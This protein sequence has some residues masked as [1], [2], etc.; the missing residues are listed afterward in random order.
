[1]TMNFLNVEGSTKAHGKHASR[2]VSTDPE[3]L[4]DENTFF[5]SLESEAGHS[6]YEE[7]L[8]RRNSNEVVGVASG[9]ESPDTGVPKSA[10]GFL[11]PQDSVNTLKDV[12]GSKNAPEPTDGEPTSKN[13]DN[14]FDTG[15]TVEFTSKTSTTLAETIISNKTGFLAPIKDSRAQETGRNTATS[16]DPVTAEGIP[17]K[18]AV[19]SAGSITVPQVTI[20]KQN[21]QSLVEHVHLHAFPKNVI[22]QSEALAGDIDETKPS[23]EMRVASRENANLAASL[24]QALSQ[25]IIGNSQPKTEQSTFSSK[26][27]LNSDTVPDRILT[28][29]E[30]GSVGAPKNPT[31]TTLPTFVERDTASATH[32]FKPIRDHGNFASRSSDYPAASPPPVQSIIGGNSSVPTQAQMNT[33][34]A[35]TTTSVML[36]VDEAGYDKMSLK[37]DLPVTSSSIQR[38]EL[39]SALA[40]PLQ[41][42]PRT[43]VLRSIFVQIA[44]NGSIGS[45]DTIEVRLSPE[46]LGL[47]KYRIS[48]TETGTII[49]VSADRPDTLDLLRRNAADLM[50]EFNAMGL[51]A[52]DLSFLDSDV[53]GEDHGSGQ[54][55]QNN[56]TKDD[57]MEDG[58]A[59]ISQS[60]VGT[61]GLDIRL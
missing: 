16:F 6:K 46:E 29:A 4:D 39:H 44:Q 12:E 34:A 25:S 37:T 31:L 58:A 11:A 47:V 7:M 10:P 33:M 23:L 28:N 48:A 50:A 15:I 51:D 14:Q 36:E 40:G 56:Q 22:R 20:N 59:V 27:L 53:D 26:A 38:V 21:R 54:K 49:V 55:A 8:N 3:Q 52:S 42:T 45:S 5:A 60:I 18:K 2:E 1:M 61:S 41:G 57:V 32:D 24:G 17:T 19:D 35:D 30:L 43:E 13:A 9:D